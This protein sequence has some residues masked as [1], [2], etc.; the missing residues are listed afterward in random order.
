MK[1][2]LIFNSLIPTEAR[3]FDEFKIGR[4]NSCSNL[5]SEKLLENSNMQFYKVMAYGLKFI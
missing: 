4:K 3:G 2:S 1:I 5:S